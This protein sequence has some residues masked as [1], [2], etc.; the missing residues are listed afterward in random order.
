MVSLKGATMDNRTSPPTSY[1]GK[2]IHDRNNYITSHAKMI[3]KYKC[4]EEVNAWIERFHSLMTDKSHGIFL[5]SLGR[6]SYT[7][8]FFALSCCCRVLRVSNHFYHYGFYVS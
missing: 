2:V 6:K 5:G 4:S 1:S 3:E 7:C 8:C